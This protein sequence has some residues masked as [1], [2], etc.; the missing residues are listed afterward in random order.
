MAGAD[1]TGFF[2]NSAA[3]VAGLAARVLALFARLEALPVPVVAL[4]DGFA[5]G[6]GNELAMSTHYRIVTENALMGQPEIKLGIFPGYGGMQ[7]LPRLVGPQRAA[8]IVLNGEPVGGRTAVTIG[9]A[10]E[11]HPAASALRAAFS[12]AVRMATGEQAP[13]LR[14]WD[15]L[16]RPRELQALWERPEIAALRRAV[17][18]TAED[19]GD[20]LAARRY[21]GRMALEALRF[22]HEHGF[23]RGME[24]DARLFGEV[25]ASPSGQYWIGR[26]LSKDPR[27]STFLTL[28][29][30]PG[31]E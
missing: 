28:M 11:F 17:A 8:E 26:F 29:P 20:L 13:P 7:R 31:A 18:P 3:G 30:A 23:R 22:G 9:L 5:L 10:D 2:G 12:A 14:T 25:T 15:S 4:V 1:V 24:N 16:S 27:Q 19:A 21:A 6:G